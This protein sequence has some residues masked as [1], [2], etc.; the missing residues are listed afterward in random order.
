MNSK[1][2]VIQANRP[3]EMIR[4]VFDS[5]GGTDFLKDKKVFIKLN[6][7]GPSGQKGAIVSETV[8]R[9]VI[10]YLKP[11]C[12]QLKLGEQGRS[13][14]KESEALFKR[15]WCRRMEKELG[16]DFV[17]LWEDEY[18]PVEVPQPLVKKRW[19]IPKSILD[20]DIVISLACLKVN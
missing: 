20:S 9:A 4:A 7:G 13:S 17:N 18:L 1:V 11:L 12:K 5:I 19:K 10:E 14:K 15:I 8:T 16:V 2:G 3:A 6:L